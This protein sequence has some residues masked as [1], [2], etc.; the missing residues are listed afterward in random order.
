[1]GKS[2]DRSPGALEG[3]PFCLDITSEEYRGLWPY[4]YEP[5]TPEMEVFHNPFAH[6]PVPFELLPEAQHW[7][8]EDGEWQCSSVYETSILSSR[9]WI[10][11]ADRPA[12]TLQ[13]LLDAEGRATDNP[14]VDVS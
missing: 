2:F 12:P 11:D 6:H 4:G 8:E 3:V 5:W 14:S 10:T 7:F 13:D 1:M 9:T